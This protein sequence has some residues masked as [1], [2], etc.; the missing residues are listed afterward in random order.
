MTPMKGGKGPNSIQYGLGMTLRRCAMAA[1]AL[2]VAFLQLAN[3]AVGAEWTEREFAKFRLLSSTTA[4][5]ISSEI[6]IGLE[7]DLEP[8]WQFYSEDPGEFGVAPTLDWTASRNLANTSVYW[9]TPTEYIYSTEPPIK[10]L[11]Y[12]GSLLVPVVLELVQVSEAFDVRLALEYATCDEF[13]VIDTV[14]LRLA[15]PLGRVQV[16]HHGERLQQALAEAR[17]SR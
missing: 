7:I 13:C 16:S 4:V 10:T 5:G 3:A 15:V 8:G 11:G 1:I 2:V 6:L 17:A 14:E 9:P 12:K